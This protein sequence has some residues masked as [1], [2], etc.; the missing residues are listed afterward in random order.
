[1]RARYTAYA[2][3]NIE[4]VESSHDPAKRH[5]MDKDGA[6]EWSKAA[7]WLGLEVSSTENGA[8]GDDDGVVEFVAKY[9]MQGR[10]VH[11]RERAIFKK[12]KDEWFFHDGIMVKQKPLVRE[13]PKVGRN[14]PCPCGSGKKFKKCCGR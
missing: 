2:T 13:G 11:H 8:E 9:E 12:V 1:M 3:G 7:E 6:E 5:E 10:I 14:D 4:F